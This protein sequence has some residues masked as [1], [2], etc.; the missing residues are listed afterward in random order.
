MRTIMILSIAAWLGIAAAERVDAA[1]P[2]AFGPVD[3][4][5]VWVD[6][7]ASWCTPC[8]RSFPWMN[9]MQDK[10]GDDGLVIIG[11]NVDSDPAEAASFLASYPPDFEIRYDPDGELATE[12][13]VVAM[14]SSYV[15]DRDGELVERHLGFKVKLQDEYETLLRESL[16]AD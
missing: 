2:E 6:F 5:V 12:F 1:L 11:V 9:A 10:Y 4:E 15:F 7:W 16:A 13:G 8:R 14:P 3:A